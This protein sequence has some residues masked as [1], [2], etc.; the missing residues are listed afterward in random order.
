VALAEDKIGG[1]AGNEFLSTAT[2]LKIL[3]AWREIVAA[4]GDVYND[5]L[6]F[7]ARAVGFR[8]H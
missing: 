2:D 4:A 6:P 8:Q 7:G 1:N 5:R 3:A